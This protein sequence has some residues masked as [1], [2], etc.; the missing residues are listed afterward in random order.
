MGTLKVP[1]SQDEA[2]DG[3]HVQIVAAC[4][5]RGRVAIACYETS[6]GGLPI[7]SL[8]LAA[9]RHAAPV[10]RGARRVAP[11]TPRPAA[12]PL[13]L[14]V[15]GGVIEAAV[16]IAQ[17]AHALV[18]VDAV[19]E[20]L[21]QSISLSEVVL[22]TTAGRPVVLTGLQGAGRVLGRASPPYPR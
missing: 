19:L 11:G 3:S 2:L 18:T 5:A 20:A 16:G 1:W 10:M 12:A 22:K 15:R 9:P 6:D 21:E 13:A 8:G 14:R 7:P 17:A 4:D